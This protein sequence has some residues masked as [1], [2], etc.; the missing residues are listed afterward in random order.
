[1][2][3]LR[4]IPD[5]GSEV[6]IIT[7]HLVLVGRDAICDIQLSDA[8][9]SRQ[10]A[11]IRLEDDRWLVRDLNSANGVLLD[12]KQ[13]PRSVL[14]HG[15]RLRFGS[16]GFRVE[17][18]QGGEPDEATVLLAR[19]GA[20]ATA[21]GYQES[22][23]RP[24][25]TGSTRAPRED[26]PK[27]NRGLIVAVAGVAMLAIAAGFWLQGQAET[28]R[29]STGAA[30]TAVPTV[31]PAASP[32]A[33]VPSP[34]VAATPTP[35]AET[36]S[37]SPAPSNTPSPTEAATAP[38]APAGTAALPQGV[39]MISTD[40]RATVLV[41]G[42]T[43]GVLQAGGF[44]RVEVAPGEHIVTFEVG[45]QRRDIVV[46]TKANEQAV[47]R[48]EIRSLRTATPTPAPR[49]PAAERPRA[50]PT[51]PQ[52][53]SA[54]RTAASA[55]TPAPTPVPVA[56]APPTPARSTSPPRIVDAGLAKGAAATARG[57]FYRALLILNDAVR[58]LDKDPQSGT[59]LVIAHAYLAWTHHGLGR[60]AEARNSAQR[61][62][63][64]DSGVM[65]KLGSFPTPVLD[66][67]K[68][69][70]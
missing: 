18:D 41:N 47:A 11:E 51:P 31:S 39:I 23:N 14:A 59:D 48:F 53:Q 50:Q 13:V 12:G 15:Q 58:R 45:K 9:V 62:L 16:V 24:T 46:R 22:D 54:P 17:T 36:P 1:M 20:K 28:S 52:P 2:D 63:G 65:A 66:L 42:Q 33:P 68:A 64:L 56:P 37:P 10:H 21:R 34:R 57:D 29:T 26:A 32:A 61:A 40:T 27:S 38:A 67:F 60:T 7:T 44:R 25:M 8:S 35:G 69:S 4:L 3:P 5:D 70:R 30:P 55:S 49:R 6:I 43:E 19:P